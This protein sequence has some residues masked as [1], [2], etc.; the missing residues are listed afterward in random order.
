MKYS[1]NQFLQTHFRFCLSKSRE[2]RIR[3]QSQ[4]GVL[5]EPNFSN[6]AA[7]GDLDND[8]DLDLV[9]NK[10][11]DVAS[12]FRNE[13]NQQLRNHY[14]KFELTGV[15]KNTFAFGT[16]ITATNKGKS[17]Y[18]EQMPIRGFESSMDPRPN[19]GLGEIDTV[20]QILIEWPDGKGELLIDVPD[21]PDNH[22]GTK[23]R[24]SAHEH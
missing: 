16:K 9:I 2:A 12:V 6:G 7:Y 3:K 19:L 14:L 5:G 10:V 1:L 22:P 21:K 17:F 8:G 4:N 24:C 11:N 23:E 15:D 18:V 13:A 20:E